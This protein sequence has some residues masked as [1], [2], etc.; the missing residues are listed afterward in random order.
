MVERLAAERGAMCLPG[1]AFGAGQ[2]QHL[3]IAFANVD[4]DGIG[5]LA[6][7]LGAEDQRP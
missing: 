6:D 2:E 3:R 1:S 7:R 5:Q 4:A